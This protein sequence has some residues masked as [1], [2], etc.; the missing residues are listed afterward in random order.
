MAHDVAEEIEAL[1]DRIGAALDQD[2]D[3]PW[4][5]HG[6]YERVAKPFDGAE[7]EDLLLRTRLAADL[8]VDHGRARFEVV[9]A[10]AIGV[11][12]Q[13]WTYWSARSPHVRLEQFGP[14][15]ESPTVL[16]R[17]VSHFECRGL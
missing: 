6:L 8:L 2:P 4:C 3:R 5:L 16:R 13:D 10:L 15:Y 7:R 9:N 12:C 17:L 11:Q 14:E 1:M